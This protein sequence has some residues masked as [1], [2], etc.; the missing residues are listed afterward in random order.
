MKHL[1]NYGLLLIVV[2]LA[3]CNK[4]RTDTTIDQTGNKP[5]FKNGNGPTTKVTYTF[6]SDAVGSFT[7]SLI[8]PTIVKVHQDFSFS[9]TTPFA[10]TT[11]YVE[12]YDDL[13]IPTF[14]ARFFGGT[15]RFA[16]PGN[17]S[18]FGAVTV[19]T[20]VFTDPINP[21][22]GDF[23]GAEDFIGTFMITGGTGH[24]LNATGSGT[25]TAHSDYT[26]PATP[27]VLF[28]GTTELHATASVSVVPHMGNGQ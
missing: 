23:T 6:S 24:Y 12:G 5:A 2:C 19:Q 16:G 25:Y 14:P 26:P 28:G 1:I 8:A 3:S 15:L 22:V 11:G 18:L 9:N 10:L 20:S 21:S 13:T 27:G 17:D 4:E 7:I